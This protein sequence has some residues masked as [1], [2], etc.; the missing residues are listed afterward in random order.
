M[1]RS[2]LCKLNSTVIRSS[3]SASWRRQLICQFVINMV[4]SLEPE[5]ESPEGWALDD[6][7]G[8]AAY[9]EKPTVRS[10]LLC[11]PIKKKSLTKDRSEDVLLKK[12]ERK[13]MMRTRCATHLEA[14]QSL[15]QQSLSNPCSI[16]LHRNMPLRT[17]RMRLS[18]KL[19]DLWSRSMR[20]VETSWRSNMRGTT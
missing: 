6:S 3:I 19:Q 5:D 8:D 1:Q 9:V 2:G 16:P 18:M 11:T 4:A 14:R 17:L 13:I 15:S 12:E 7:D 10:R 20:N